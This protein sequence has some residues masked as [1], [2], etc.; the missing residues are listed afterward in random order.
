MTGRFVFDEFPPVAWRVWWRHH[1]AK[2]NGKR[3][4]RAF[5]DFKTEEEAEK[6]KRSMKEAHPHRLICVKP[7]YPT[8]SKRE[9]KYGER[10]QSIAIDL[11]LQRKPSR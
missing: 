1:D 9:A 10:Q 11:P 4:R 3:P 8:L 6:L 7:R 2:L 5:R